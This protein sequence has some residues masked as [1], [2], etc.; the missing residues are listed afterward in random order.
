[1]PH[2]LQDL[3]FAVRDIRDRRSRYP[4]LYIEAAM[5]LGSDLAAGAPKRK[6][7]GCYEIVGA[8]GR[9]GMGEVFHARDVRLGRSA[10][11]R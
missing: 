8:L 10:R 5:G 4:S 7:V 2:F 6:V 1:M 11:A 3:R 9:G